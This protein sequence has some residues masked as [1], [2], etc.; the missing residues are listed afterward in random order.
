MVETE[1]SERCPGMLAEVYGS[2]TGLS[3]HSG[4]SEKEVLSVDG[5]PRDT[6]AAR[7]A[8]GW[9]CHC[10]IGPAADSE[11]RRAA[12]SRQHSG[13]MVTPATP[14]SR[15]EEGLRGAGT[16]RTVKVLGG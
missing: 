16:E 14:I 13:V 12:G 11:C 3:R 10:L 7:V 4:L 5:G 15:G 2:G 9:Y 8:D 6:V 1:Q